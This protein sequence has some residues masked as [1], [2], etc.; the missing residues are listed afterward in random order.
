MNGH[1]FYL[2]LLLQ[3]VARGAGN[4]RDDGQLF[5]G[6]GIEQ[7]AF[8]HIG[9][10][11]NHHAQPFS[12]QCALLGLKHHLLQLGLELLYLTCCVGLLQKIQL[13]FRKV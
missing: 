7:G 3:F 12:K 5:T 6:Q 4:G 2:K 13:L 10:T 11:G 1:A 8:A 9:L